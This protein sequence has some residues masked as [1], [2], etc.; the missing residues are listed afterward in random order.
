MG[1]AKML[2]KGQKT[3]SFC[4]TIDYLSPEVLEKK[5]YSFS[6]DYWALGV[7]LYEMLAG[8]YFFSFF[9]SFFLFLKEK[10]L[11]M[12]LFRLSTFHC[13]FKKF[14]YSKNFICRCWI[15]RCNWSSCKRFNIK[16]FFFFFFFLKR[17][18]LLLFN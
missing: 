12:I 18:I 1:F 9:L 2:K 4:G 3:S 8:Y 15:W 13:Y 14:N 16:G 7:L 10:K 5:E 11:K 17:K 6:C